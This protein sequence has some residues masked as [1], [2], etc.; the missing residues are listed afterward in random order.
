[1]IRKKKF[2]GYG[3]ESVAGCNEHT[4]AILDQPKADLGEVGALA[5]TIDSDE[6]DAIR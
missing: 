5:D 3:P 6:G 2:I 1:M 4:E